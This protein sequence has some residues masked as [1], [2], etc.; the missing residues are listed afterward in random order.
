QLH[1][2]DGGH[3]CAGRVEILHQGSWATICGIGWSTSDAS[4][5]C[6]QLGCRVA[7][8]PIN[9]SIFGIRPDSIQLNGLGC[10][11]EETH[12]WPCPT[13]SWR[14]HNCSRWLE[15]GVFCSESPQLRLVDGGHRCAGRVEILYQGSWGTICDFYWKKSD[16][17]VVCTQLRC[18]EALDIIHSA[19]LGP[20]SGPILMNLLDCTGE[21]THVRK[22]PSLGWPKAFCDHQQDAGVICS[23]EEKRHR[24][25]HRDN[26]HRKTEAGT[27]VLHPQARTPPGRQR[28]QQEEEERMM[29]PWTLQSRNPS[30]RQFQSWG[31]VRL[32][33][34][35]GTCPSERTLDRCGLK[36]SGVRG[37]SPSSGSAP[38]RPVLEAA[39]SMVGLL[40]LSAQVVCCQLGCEVT[41]ST[42]T[43]ARSVGGGDGEI[44]TDRFHS[45]GAES[46]LWSC[47]VRALGVPACAPGNAAS[48]VC[49]GNQTQL[50][51]QCK[52]SLSDPAGS[53]ASE[54]ER[55]S[56]CAGRV[57]I[58]HQDS[59]GT[60]CDDSWDLRDAHVVFRQLD[61]GVALNA[62]ASAHFGQGSGPIWLDELSC[63]GE[64]S[65]VW[66]C[67]SWGR[68]QHGCRHKEDA[69]V[70]C[71]GLCSQGPQHGRSRE[72]PGWPLT[73]SVW[74]S[75]MEATTL[76]VIFIQLGC[77][78]SGT[79]NSDVPA[80]EVLPNCL[81]LQVPDPRAAQLW[82]LH[83]YCSPPCLPQGSWGLLPSTRAGRGAAAAF[84]DREKLRLR[85]GDSVCSGRVE[86]WHE[87]SWGTVCDGSW[88]LAEVCQQLGCGPAM[89]TLGEA[90]FGPGN[91][92]IWLDE[93]QCRGGE[94]SLWALPGCPGDRATASMKTQA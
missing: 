2:V 13:W 62:T 68:G 37:R 76:S 74:C 71:S 85:G 11:G 94:P 64:E 47:H 69:G 21:E 18:G 32:R 49:S 70:I 50:L 35:W 29:L 38:E 23:E 51:P 28:Q 4:V 22:C 52:D 41:L 90:A 7:P 42:L 53:A 72:S 20:G 12:V 75:P 56:C 9:A 88:G 24:N 57:E 67:L 84:P 31:A 33:L 1:L 5:V 91:G 60:I 78:D 39:A 19:H 81:L 65:H 79:L 89:D 82:P 44:R 16:G 43:G 55:G 66:K 34:S 54:G 45:S 15:A 25:R 80:R 93:V 14:Q 86:V 36:R 30:C 26:S 77:Q 48:V 40:N 46:S 63:T 8:I 61:C 27:E 92:S 10:T 6:R 3:C 83:R 58:L 17:Q 73:I 59:W 87:G